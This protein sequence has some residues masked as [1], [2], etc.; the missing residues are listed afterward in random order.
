M[1]IDTVIAIYEGVPILGVACD[2]S[3]PITKVGR[4]EWPPGPFVTTRFVVPPSLVSGIELYQ[5]IRDVL[6]AGFYCL[7]TLNTLRLY[8]P[9]AVALLLDPEIDFAHNLPVEPQF[10]LGGHDM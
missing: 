3:A 9:S 5:N 8:T 2:T 6:R 1:S 7:H 4:L 10:F